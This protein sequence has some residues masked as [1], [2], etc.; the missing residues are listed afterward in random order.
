MI[1]EQDCVALSNCSAWRNTQQPHQKLQLDDCSSC[2]NPWMHCDGP[3]TTGLCN[4]SPPHTY[5]AC[6]I[7]SSRQMPGIPDSTYHRMH[8]TT[9][10]SNN[11]RPCMRNARCARNPNCASSQQSTTSSSRSTGII[12]ATLG[13]LVG[14]RPRD[15][16]KAVFRSG[17]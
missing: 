10:S 12:L 7:A 17:F 8:A 13:N 3:T 15:I 14:L 9:N 4:G 2:R 11:A 1:H 5:A 16:C 6:G